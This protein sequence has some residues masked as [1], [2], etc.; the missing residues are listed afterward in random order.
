MRH[1]WPG[2]VG[3]LENIAKRL[4]VLGNEEFIKR[5]LKHWPL[6]MPQQPQEWE[7]EKSEIERPE[8]I[9]LKETRR[10]AVR[11]AEA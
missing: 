3:E 10:K 4:A 7:P 9:S 2:N 5:E 8:A 11:R 6:T 1:Q